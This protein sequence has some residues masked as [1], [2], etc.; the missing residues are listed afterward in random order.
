MTAKKRQSPATPR[1]SAS[2]AAGKKQANSSKSRTLI[3]VAGVVVLASVIGVYFALKQQPADA[4]AKGCSSGFTSSVTPKDADWKTDASLV[5]T[6]KLNDPTYDTATRSC[7]WQQTL[8]VASHQGSERTSCDIHA[9][10]QR[11]ACPAAGQVVTIFSDVRTGDP[12]RAPFLPS[13]VYV[14]EVLGDGVVYTS[15]KF[16]Y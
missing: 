16:N 12:N 8:T 5:I 6:Q 14:E 15:A 3:A 10:G 9:D 2:R 13:E 11:I 7:A 4:L 1:R